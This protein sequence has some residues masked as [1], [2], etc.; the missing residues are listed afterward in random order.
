MRLICHKA[1]QR[2]FADGIELLNATRDVY[3][4]KDIFIA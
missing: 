2:L 1:F 4:D 3:L